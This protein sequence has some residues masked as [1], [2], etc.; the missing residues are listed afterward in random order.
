MCFAVLH[1]FYDDVSYLRLLRGWIG[2]APSSLEATSVRS[3]DAIE[4]SSLEQSLGG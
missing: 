1:R 4:G 2:S 3:G